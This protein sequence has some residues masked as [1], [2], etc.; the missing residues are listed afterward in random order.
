MVGAAVALGQEGRSDGEIVRSPST[1]QR[2][3]Q[4]APVIQARRIDLLYG[5]TI[6][7]GE[8]NP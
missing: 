8:A 3:R 5:Q 2:L 6:H 7:G 4:L 1:V